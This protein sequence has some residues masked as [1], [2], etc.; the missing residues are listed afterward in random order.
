V[1]EAGVPGYD[2]Q[3]WYGLM[4]P[5][6]TAKTIVAGLNGG[7]VRTLDL[8]D[9]RRHLVADG[10]DAVGSTPEEFGTFLRS[11]MARWAVIVK[12]SGMKAE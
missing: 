9:F 2:F 5:S 11:E 4:L 6:G 7:V 8:P 1:A 10:S 3:S 12:S